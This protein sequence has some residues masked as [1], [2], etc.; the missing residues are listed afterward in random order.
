MTTRR[1]EFIDYCV[2]LLGGAQ[3]VS[4]KRMFSG[5]GLYY[6]GLFIA[7]VIDEQLYLK[8]DEAGAR[9]F[10]EA[11]SSQLVVHKSTDRPI[12]LSYWSVPAEV[13]ESPY[14]IE[15]WRR[16]AIAAALASRASKAPKVPKP[17]RDAKPKPASAKTTRT[18]NVKS[19]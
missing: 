14:L 15:P 1:N 8:A 13:M 3:A 11:G 6:D 5:H 2:E 10:E 16:G 18:K 9:A 12:A 19:G 17:K 7:I 4:A